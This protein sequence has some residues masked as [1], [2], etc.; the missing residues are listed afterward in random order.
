MRIAVVGAGQA[1]AP[2]LQSIQDLDGEVTL[3]RVVARSAGKLGALELPEG[4][5]ISTRLEDILEDASIRAVLVLT[6][7][8]THL[9]I[10]QRLARAG[11]HVLVEKPLDV[12]LDKA[13]QM[14]DI[15]EQSGVKLAVML[16]HRM[17][18]ASLALAQLVKDGTM[19]QL[20]SASASIRWWRPQSYY[21]EPGRGTLARDG[22]GVLMTQ[23]IH[24]LDLLLSLTGMPDK[25]LAMAS[26][27][28]AH[29][30]ECE[31]T[32]AA[33]MHYPHGAIGSIDATT[34]AY[35]G[36]PERIALNFEHGS[37]TL[38]AGE[39]QAE[40]MAGRKIQAG[41]RQATG[42]GANLMAFDHAFHRAVLQDFVTAIRNDAEPAV[43]G[44]SALQAQRL[45]AA[46]MESSSRGTAVT[47]AP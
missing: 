43:T 46:V 10:V 21:D 1:S 14:V 20:L 22:G 42:S 29:R 45:I 8:N 13:Q 2:H 30:M 24:T 15:C 4:T 19:G 17:R 36:F 28:A 25:V 32:V 37:A 33:V 11:K 40:L 27:S 31:D 18:E 9:D 44:R 6:P 38:E 5:A 26:T 12:T 3:A 47:I 35:P 16:Q 41:T 7:P 39:L 34:A 23:A